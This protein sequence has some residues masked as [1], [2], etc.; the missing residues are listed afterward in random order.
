ML[1]ILDPRAEPGVPI[2]QY[3]LSFDCTKGPITIGL[4]S[5]GFPD[6]T[7]VL[8]ALGRALSAMLPQARIEL[9]ARLDPSVIAEPDEIERVAQ[10]CDVVVTAI[11][12]CGSCTSSAVRDAVNTARA[13]VPA[14]A[15]VS[16]RF[17]ETGDYVARSVGMPEIPRVMLP[18]PTSG[19][20]LARIEEITR[21]I[22]ADVIA[23]W[24]GRANG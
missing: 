15:L 12:H 4:L 13:G 24:S 20:G 14:A 2:E 18:H 3:A 22:A 19:T 9:F 23:A 10:A 17:W 11:G 1:E 5:N 8:T 7:A 21:S 16:E 6:A